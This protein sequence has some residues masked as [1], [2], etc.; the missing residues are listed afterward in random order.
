MILHSSTRKIRFDAHELVLDPSGALYWPEKQLLVFS[1]L[2]LGKGS[3]LAK[4]ALPLPL[5]DT[6]DTLKRMQHV[7]HA[8]QPHSI[9]CLGD[10][11][12]DTHAHARMGVQEIMLLTQLITQATQWIW[13]TGNHDREIPDPIEG[14]RHA[15]LTLETITFRHEPE[16]D[17][18]IQIVGHYHPKTRLKLGGGNVSGKCFIHSGRL[19]IMPSFGSFTGGLDRFDT[20]ITEHATAKHDAYLLYREKV[21]KI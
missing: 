11:F 19:L 21:W 14:M 7:I 9:L 3:Y 12:H 16:K 15:H 18:S 8:Y 6:L 5:Y 17:A 2:H 20:A 10:S 4:R 13:I 1:D